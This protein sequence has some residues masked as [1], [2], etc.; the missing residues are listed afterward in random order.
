MRKARKWAAG[1]ASDDFH[2]NPDKPLR[3]G[4]RGTYTASVSTI[5]A[6][7]VRADFSG[8]MVPLWAYATCT[9]STL[10]CFAFP[11]SIVPEARLGMLWTAATQAMPRPNSFF[12]P[13]A[14]TP[15]CSIRLPGRSIAAGRLPSRDRRSAQWHPLC[16][17]RISAV[18]IGSVENSYLHLDPLCG[19]PSNRIEGRF[20]RSAVQAISQVSSVKTARFNGYLI[21]YIAHTAYGPRSL[22]R[23][24]L[25]VP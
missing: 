24:G 23:R 9:P 2:Y 6:D 8:W 25:L 3:L 20:V 11:F 13:P 4:P 19:R 12:P 1:P 21:R 15:F 22:F 16:L 10:E 17:R 18:R 14:L 7:G 5:T